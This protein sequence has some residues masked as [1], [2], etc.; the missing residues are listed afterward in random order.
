MPSFPDSIAHQQIAS[1]LTEILGEPVAD[2]SR[3]TGTPLGRDRPGDFA[4][5]GRGLSFLTEY[6]SVSSLSQLARTIDS[7]S[8][9]RPTL[10]PA[11]FPLLA[12]PY[13]GPDAQ[14]WCERADIPWL[15]F[16]GNARII[17]PGIF[18]QNLGHANRFKKTGRPGTAFGTRGSKI[19]RHLLMEPD[20]VMQQRALAK[21]AGLNE[22]HTS[23]I[24]SRLVEDG[25]VERSE[26]GI[27][28][29]DPAALLDAWREEYR[30]DRHYVIRGHIAASNGVA[31][32]RSVADTL[33]RIDAPYAATALSAA[34]FYTH[35]T[36]FR[37]SA[38]YLDAAPSQGLMGDLGFREEP[39]GANTWLI[40]PNDDGVFDG[41]EEVEGVRCVHPVQAYLDLK[42]H[43]ERSDEAAEELRRLLLLGESDDA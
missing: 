31:V 35:Y 24:V 43:P 26:E 15:D 36:G 37:L 38:I 23:R 25:L 9:L 27:Q 22:G 21:S 17:V 33:S 34:W 8:K 42:D 6:K 16:S 29:R 14:A 5:T 19:A 7:L 39:R 18:Y 4:L 30:L 13:M 12:V 20:T 11:T 1:R 40:V 3:Q 28:V 10:P 2:I 32:T 41:A